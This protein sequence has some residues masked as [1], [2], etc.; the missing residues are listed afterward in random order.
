MGKSA[1]NLIGNNFWLEGP[2]DLR[3]TRLNCILQDLFRD[4]KLDQIWPNMPNMHIWVRQIWSSGVSLKRS[5]KK[6]F[7]RVGLRSMGP[8]SQKLWPILIFAPG[9]GINFVKERMT[10]PQKWHKQFDNDKGNN[11]VRIYVG[12][13]KNNHIKN[14]WTILCY[15]H[16]L[17]VWMSCRILA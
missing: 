17:F 9:P 4:T 6:Q 2:I 10:L 15:I 8:S 12:N 5:C 1:K 13:K 14:I 16:L 11:F 3:P 7:R